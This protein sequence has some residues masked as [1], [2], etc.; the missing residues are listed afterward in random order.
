MTR[1]NRLYNK[2][3][4]AMYVKHKE[5]VQSLAKV[6]TNTGP[7]HC[8]VESEIDMQQS[9]AEYRTWVTIDDALPW[10]ASFSFS[11]WCCVQGWL[12]VVLW[13]GPG[14]SSSGTESCLYAIIINHPYS[15]FQTPHKY[16]IAHHIG[17][18]SKPYPTLNYSL[19]ALV[20]F[21]LLLNILE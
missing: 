6:A 18:R 21:L 15:N 19:H 20:F 5:L 3:D 16:K 12:P 13:L 1:W 4:K 17:L 10:C 2:A 7:L 9:R 14:G 11:F 8:V